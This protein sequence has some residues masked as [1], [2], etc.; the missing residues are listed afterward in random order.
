[1]GVVR[2]VQSDA[3]QVAPTAPALAS[4]TRT[5]AERLD[6]QTGIIGNNGAI[7]EPGE[8]A[9]FGERIFLEGR[10]RLEVILGLARRDA[11]GL[12]IDDQDAGATKQRTQLAQ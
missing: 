10:G 4:H 7:R 11:G 1:M 6:L 3:S 8:I 9:R 2:L 12:E 5:A